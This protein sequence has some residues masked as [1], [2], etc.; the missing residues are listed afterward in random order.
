MTEASYI[1][2][3][4]EA[5]DDIKEY[6]KK[7]VSHAEYLSGGKW[8]KIPIYKCETLPDGR[9]AIFVMFDHEAPDHIDGIRFYHRS[10]FIWAGGKEN[11]NKEE[12][13]EGVLYRY[14]LRIVQSSDK[15]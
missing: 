3:T 9:V 2:L 6:F 15:S 5:I 10:G 11:L 8:T 13:D 12:F 1:P 4:D 14:T 7:V